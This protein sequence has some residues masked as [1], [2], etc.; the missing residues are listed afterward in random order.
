MQPATAARSPVSPTIGHNNDPG[1]GFINYTLDMAVSASY[2]DGFGQ[3]G[4]LSWNLLL[5]EQ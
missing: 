3:S 2:L 5:H 4:F 1:G